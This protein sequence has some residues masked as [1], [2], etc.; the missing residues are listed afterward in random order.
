MPTPSYRMKKPSTWHG[1]AILFRCC[2]S[3]I[4]T[5][6]RMRCALPTPM[7]TAAASSRISGY[8]PFG[9]KEFSDMLHYVRTG[10]FVNNL[11][12]DAD[13]LNEYAFALGALG[14]LPGRH[15]RSSFCRTGD[16]SRVSAIGKFA[17]AT[18]SAITIRPQ[19]IFARSM[20]STWCRLHKAITSRMI[21][22][23]SSA[24]MSQHL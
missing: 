11:L 14:A 5:L 21:T 19:R 9:S 13:N 1:V 4:P 10:E 16:C 3:D 12:K 23:T 2:A 15:N 22:P 7:P 17:S 6:R 24:L 20:V 18:L 8:Y